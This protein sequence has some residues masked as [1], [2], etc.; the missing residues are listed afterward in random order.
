MAEGLAALLDDRSVGALLDLR[1]RGFDL[2]VI[3]ISPLAFTALPRDPDSRTALRMWRL[4]R[5]ALHFRFERLG[6]AV[7]E[8]DGQRPLGEVIEEVRAFRRFARFTSA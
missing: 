7:A 1:G 6:V 5:D 2:V 8:W 4:W 3:D